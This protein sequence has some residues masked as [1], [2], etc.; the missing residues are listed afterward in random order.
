MY[1]ATTSQ[2]EI[3]TISCDL[4]LN[5]LFTYHLL[6]EDEEAKLAY[7]FRASLSKYE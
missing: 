6:S 4:N 1:M 3:E 7:A 5:Q 2:T